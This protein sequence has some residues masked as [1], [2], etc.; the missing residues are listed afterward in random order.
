METGAGWDEEEIMG[1]IPSSK[2]DRLHCYNCGRE[3]PTA[4][5]QP[6]QQRACPRCNSPLG[7]ETFFEAKQTTEQGVV[8]IKKIPKAMVKWDVYGP[9]EVDANPQAKHVKETPLLALDIDL[10]LGILRMIFPTVAEKIGDAQEVAT[11]PN[12]SYEKQRRADANSQSDNYTPENQNFTATYSRNWLQPTSYWKMGDKE[13]AQFMQQ[14]F[15]SGCRVSLVGTEIVDIRE[16]A[17]AKEW[18]SC[19]LH[20]GV[21]LFPPSIADN[22]V[23]FNQRL[24]DTMNII[25][26]WIVRCAAG[27]TI[28]DKSKIDSREVKGQKMTPGRLFGLQTKAHGVVAA[29]R[30]SIVQFEFKLDNQIF[31]YPAMLIEMCETISGISPQTFG[32]GTTPGVETAKGQAQQLD[33]SLTKLNIYWE[34]EK[35]EHAEASQNAIECLQKLMKAGAVTE[36]FESIQANGSEFRNNYV[37]FQKL[38]GRVKVSVNTDEG[39]PQ[40]PMQIRQTITQL[41]EEAGKG[42]KIAESILDVVPNQEAFMSIMAP[43]GTVIPGAAQRAK[44][45]QDINTLMENDWIIVPGPP[46]PM[47]GAPTTQQQLPVMPEGWYEDFPIARDTIRLYC[48]ENM[49]YRKTN[50]GGWQR[51]EQYNAMLQQQD[52]Q[53]AAAEAKRS[54]QV[55]MAGSPPPPVP[56]PARAAGACTHNQRCSGRGAESA[57]HLAHVASD[58]GGHSDGA[59][60]RGG[61]DCG[62]CSESAGSIKAVI[63]SDSQVDMAEHSG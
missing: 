12:A 1:D 59:G 24:N 33:T 57:S 15:P 43:P 8:G 55:K 17:L 36:I 31:T 5:F 10:D 25:D 61:E 38:Q 16:A 30:D 37:N 4:S 28:Y 2:P 63:H 58:D 29:L 19:Q 7:P 45:L 3:T 44:T 13:F 23:P 48:Q 34:N 27:I 32:A 51:I 50:P 9:L 46:D 21:G 42:N 62:R 53:E 49:D 56:N 40:S 54:L 35:E 14:K 60:Y 18:T 26:D 41:V 39:L 22:V 6:D 52:M 11:T 20:E 47:T